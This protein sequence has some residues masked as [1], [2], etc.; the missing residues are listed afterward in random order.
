MVNHRRGRDQL[1][2]RQPICCPL[3]SKTV[4]GQVFVF[5][6]QKLTALLINNIFYITWCLVDAKMDFRSP[7]R[8]KS[9]IKSQ[10][11]VNCQLSYH[12]P[13]ASKAFSAA[14]SSASCLEEPSPSA[15]MSL[16]RYTPI[17]KFFA[18][19]GPHSFSTAYEGVISTFS[20]ATS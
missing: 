12:H 2:R 18:W 8:S 1:R 7:S 5:V 9:V 19:S 13:L 4:N 10:S 20:C 15:T 17:R 14:F 11:I 6:K 3:F 16:P